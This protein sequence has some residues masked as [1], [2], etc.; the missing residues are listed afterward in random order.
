MTDFSSSFF[1]VIGHAVSVHFAV[2]LFVISTFSY[3][4]TS[5]S[6]R[7][8]VQYQSRLIARWSFWLASAATLIAIIFGLFAYMADSHDDISH[9]LLNEHRNIALFAGFLVIV[10]IPWLLVLRS[11]DKEEGYGFMATQL[12]ACLAIVYVTWTGSVLVYQ[13][14]VGVKNLP[15]PQAHNHRTYKKSTAK[16]D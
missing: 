9:F 4:I 6:D 11:D 10:L 15:D 3:A 2:A 12:I 16:Y 8:V 14:G 1:I 13:Y 7:Y 5:L